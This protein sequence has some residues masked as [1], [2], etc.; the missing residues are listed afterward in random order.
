MP[1]ERMIMSVQT[2]GERLCAAMIQKVRLC[3]RSWKPRSVDMLGTVDDVEVFYTECFYS[4]LGNLGPSRSTL[5]GKHCQ[6][7]NL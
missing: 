7:K 6:R 1:T 2:D 4:I 5:E 3:H